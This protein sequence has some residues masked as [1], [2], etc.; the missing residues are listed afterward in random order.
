[1]FDRVML[2]FWCFLLGFTVCALVWGAITVVDNYLVRL[3]GS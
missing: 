1:M 2:G 3:C